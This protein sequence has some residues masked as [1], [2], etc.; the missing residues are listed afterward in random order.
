QA[1][2]VGIDML[3][4]G[5]M[6]RGSWATDMAEAV[7][8]FVPQRVELEWKGPGGGREGS[9]LR[10]AGATLKKTRKL[11]AHELPFLKKH[12]PGPFKV[13]VPAPSNFLLASYKAGVTDRRSEEHTSELQ[14]RVDLVCR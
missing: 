1:R 6:R 13:T 2:R 3:S 5:E 9:T 4:D 10:A 8:G 12:A 7:D 14:S 11:N